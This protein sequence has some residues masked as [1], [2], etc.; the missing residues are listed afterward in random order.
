MIDFQ[1]SAIIEKSN[2]RPCDSL[3][4]A[5]APWEEG[6]GGGELNYRGH[7]SAMIHSKLCAV[8]V[9]ITKIRVHQPVQPKPL[10]SEAN[11]IVNVVSN[12][13]KVGLSTVALA[14][15]DGQPLFYQTNPS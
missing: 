7:K 9:T 5:P 1:S 8:C 15:V 6:R 4:G 3:P 12:L 14:K 10:M 13:A 2:H 11:A